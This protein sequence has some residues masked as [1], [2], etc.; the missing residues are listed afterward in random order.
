MKLGGGMLRATWR[1]LQGDVW[2]SYDHNLLYTLK[3]SKMNFLRMKVT[4][5]AS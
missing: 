1:E 3:F 5:N 2:G 4:K